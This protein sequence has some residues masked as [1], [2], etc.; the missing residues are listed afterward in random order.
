MAR[1]KLIK[2][3]ISSQMDIDTALQNL[4]AILYCLEDESLI[5]WTKKELSG[6]D[7][8]D[9]LPQYRLLYG[10]V[11]ADF[12][13]G[14]MHYTKHPFAI[15]HLDKKIQDSLLE[16]PINLSIST[17]NEEIKKDSS[18]G[19][20]ISPEY[21]SMLQSNSNAKIV[22]AYVDINIVE[23][24]DI[25]SK[26]KTK[27]LETLLFLEKEFGNLDNLD[28]D[29]SVKNAEEIK[30]IVQY[31]QVTLYDNSVSIGD[32][33]KIKNSDIVTNK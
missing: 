3:F 15:N 25:I 6:Y 17:L 26:V 5:N 9:T 16:I 4:M 28:I 10:R 11:I 1:S 7:I 13:V 27:I 20:P 29:I 33:N 12:F 8:G 30:T 14:H 32:N 2:D 19:S 21:Y 18:F 22:K 31:I 23:L 24:S